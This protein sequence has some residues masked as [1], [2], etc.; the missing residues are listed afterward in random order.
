MRLRTEFSNIKFT[1]RDNP[2]GPVLYA[3]KH[4][5]DVELEPEEQ[6]RLYLA[7]E[8]SDDEVIEMFYNIIKQRIVERLKK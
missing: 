4:R 7:A 1:V 8:L 5:I 2:N 3:G 6:M